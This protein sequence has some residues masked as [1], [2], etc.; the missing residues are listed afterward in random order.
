MAVTVWAR[1][2]GLLLLVLLAW[3]AC[4]V[5][6]IQFRAPAPE[7]EENCAVAG[8]EDGNGQEDCADLAC[9]Q[10]ASCAVPSCSDGEQNGGETDVDCGGSCPACA[11]GKACALDR[12]CASFG[13]CDGLRCRAATS[14]AEVLQRYPT[15]RDGV[16]AIGPTGAPAG[17]PAVDAVCDM[18]RDGGGWTLLMKSSGDAVFTYAAAAWTDDVLLNETDLTTQPGNAKYAAFVS[19]PV[20]T[21]RGELDGYRFTHPFPSLTARQIFSGAAVFVT[22]FPTFNTDGA[23]WSTQPNC[24]RFGTNLTDGFSTV[25]FGWSANQEDDCLTNDTG[26]GLGVGGYGAGYRCTS[27]EC[28]AGNVDV[29]G[30]GF[31]WGK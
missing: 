10:L 15:A 6:S 5:D 12:D 29:G 31:L 16:Y 3:A 9:A 27:S 23:N 25:R 26:I 2:A 24:Q 8:D 14:C 7:L 17:A 30:V 21:L 11:G 20:G 4:A 13:A 1:L 18:S 22:P 19:L 28:S